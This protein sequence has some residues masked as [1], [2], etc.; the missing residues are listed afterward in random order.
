MQ[1]VVLITGASSGFGEAMAGYLSQKGFSV[2]GTSRKANPAT[3]PNGFKM[4]PMDVQDM[5]SIRVSVF[6][7]AS[8]FVAPKA[9]A[10]IVTIK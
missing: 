5:D 9:M 1:K 10:A 4:I 3:A 7:S 2:W 6:F 8:P